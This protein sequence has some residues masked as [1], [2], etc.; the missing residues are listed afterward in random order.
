VDVSLPECPYLQPDLKFRARMKQLSQSLAIPEDAGTYLLE[1]LKFLGT[2][3]L[4]L[5]TAL[6]MLMAG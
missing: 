2:L 4:I 6:I 3:G 1:I 5:V